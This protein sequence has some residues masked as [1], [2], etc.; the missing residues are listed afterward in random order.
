MFEVNKAIARRYYEECWNKGDADVVDQLVAP[1]CRFHDA[2]FPH[3][4]S[5]PESLR[6][7]IRMCRTAFPDLH[8]TI[9]RIIAE[10]EEVVVHWTRTGTQQRQFLGLAPTHH[11]TTVTGTSIFRLADGRIAEQWADWNL[12]T[13]LE[14]LGVAQP[15]Y[16]IAAADR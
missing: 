8:F 13:L 7:H 11:T 10:R 12:V 2:V 4:G 1:S 5:G 15:V 9:D 3:L 16:A 14:Q 6:R